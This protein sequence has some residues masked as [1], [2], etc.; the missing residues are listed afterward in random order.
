MAASLA[1]TPS[2]HGTAA[3]FVLASA[4]PERNRDIADA[5]ARILASVG[6]TG[7][8]GAAPARGPGVAFVPFRDPSEGAFTLDVPRGWR[9][10]GG[11]R[12]LAPVDVRS[13]VVASSPDDTMHLRIGDAELP[14]FSLPTPQLLQLGFGEGAPY[15][16][17]YGVN[18]IVLRYLPGEQF[19]RHWVTTRV[20]PVCADLQVVSAQPL[21]QS[22]QAMNAIMARHGS[23]V[24]SQRLH[25]GDTA[26]RCR[27][28]STPMVG[29]LFV[30]TLLTAGGGGGGVWNVDQ[31]QGYLSAA[32]RA[33]QAQ[34]ILAH[35]VGSGRLNPD[36]VRMQQNVTAATSGIVAETGAHIARVISDS[37]W[38]RQASQAE[39][40]RKRSNQIRG[41]ED[42]RDP[43]TGQELQ[44]ES[45][46]NY[47]WIDP[48]GNIAGTN[49]HSRPALDFRELVRLP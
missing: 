38:S 15:S 47:Y 26:F 46:A 27:Q 21:P 3:Q 14:T 39:I 1:W 40:S 35:M 4:P 2:A 13:S 10:T 37:Y 49:V 22:V 7:E 23:P 48:R 5:F 19:A 45:G 41:V 31:L 9:V 12:R 44:V 16:P 8:A 34:A 29:Y 20:S 33:S 18:T 6:L 42:V 28:G 30:A 32:D 36:W 43:V 17:G 24:M 25:A 11:L